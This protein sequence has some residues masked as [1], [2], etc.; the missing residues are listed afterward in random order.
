MPHSRVIFYTIGFFHTTPILGFRKVGRWSQVVQQSIEDIHLSQKFV[1][2]I[3]LRP[4]I[5]CSVLAL[6]NDVDSSPALWTTARRG[7]FSK[8][9]RLGRFSR[10]RLSIR[11]KI[12]IISTHIHNTT[13][14]FRKFSISLIL[15]V[16]EVQ[17]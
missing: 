1:L 4:R 12:S 14:M 5:A 8:L 11:V 3:D 16:F 17:D 9:A 15:R 6:L 10:C 13:T 2:S 7:R